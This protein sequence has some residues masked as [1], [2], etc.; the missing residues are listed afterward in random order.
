MWTGTWRKVV[1]KK[2]QFRW[3]RNKPEY[4]KE[5]KKD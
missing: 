4:M 1:L 3:T 5:R 2:A